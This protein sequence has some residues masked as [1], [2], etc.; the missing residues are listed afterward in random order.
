MITRKAM[1]IGLVLLALA[2]PATALAL[3]LRAA[4]KHPPAD[5]GRTPTATRSSEAPEIGALYASARASMHGCTASVVHSRGRNTLI[6]AGH[7]V[8][9]SGVGMVFA[10]GQSG[11][12]GPFGRWTVTAAY[13]EPEWVRRHDPRA[14]V[15]FLT[16]A[17]QT[18]HGVSRE[19]EQVTGAYQLGP[20]A[21]PGQWVMITGYPA[22]GPNDPITCTAKVYL[23]QTFP[24]FDCQGF[25]G[26]TSGSPWLRVTRH[27]TRIV[28]V[29]GG[30]N[31]GGC[32]DYTSYSSRLTPDADVAYD[33]ASGDEPADVAPQRGS[34]GC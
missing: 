22:G 26:G 5:V 12:H 27:G 3:T 17:P 8:V 33:R 6:T 19:I 34:D 16:V 9:G 31:Q 25:V 10:P 29:I 15:A 11:G 28:G 7:C 23:T 24:S 4:A 18:I 32:Y 13:V 21:A 14:D 20:A 2:L 1:L 30:L